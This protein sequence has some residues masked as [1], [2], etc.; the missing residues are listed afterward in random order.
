[1]DA[2]TTIAY[3]R[4]LG[5]FPTG[6]CVVACEDEQ[7]PL[8]LTINS[9]TSVSLEP[10]LVL[11]CLH[12]QSD[13]RRAFHAARRFSVNV[14]SASD[15]AQSR[16]FA[17]QAHRIDAEELDSAPGRAPFLKG[18]VA[19]LECL[20]RK[21]LEIGDHTAMVGEVVAFDTRDGDALMFF[22][23]RYGRASAGEA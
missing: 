18:S 11:W 15:E 22:R 12:H 1:V 4:A 2:E 13:R 20:T 5:A 16:R 14:L 7:G 10:P 3:R 8:G 19:R 23:G 9:F 6:V 21:R 17:G